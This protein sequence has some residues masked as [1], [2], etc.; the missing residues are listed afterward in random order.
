MKR[1]LFTKAIILWFVSI[2]CASNSFGQSAQDDSTYLKNSLARTVDNFNKSIG[3]Q[4]R[5]YSGTEYLPYDRT[6]KGNALYPLEATTWQ[7]GAVNYD[8]FTYKDVPIMY[9]IYKDVVVILLYNKFSMLTLLSDRVHDFSL[10]DHHFV[11]VV[12]DSLSAN[13]SGISTGFYEQLYGG[14]VEVLAKR[15]KSIQNSTN[16]TATIETY[17]LAKDE[18]YI[19]KGNTYYDVGSQGSVLKVFKDKKSQLQ[20]YIRDN[21]IKFKKDPE[22]AM[23][24]IAAYYDHLT[25]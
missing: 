9:D 19:R 21:N 7:S 22:D 24:K 5:L 25:N 8:G 3:Q 10:P 20:Q 11:R 13:N 2:I 16:V 4:S 12:T 17:F 14:K 15:I 6:I 23:A 18:Y 1:S